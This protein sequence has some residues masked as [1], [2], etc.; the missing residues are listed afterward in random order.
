MINI[1][2]ADC[3]KGMA[4]MPDKAYQLAIV[5]PPYFEG[6]QK[7]KYYEGKNNLAAGG[8]Y[9]SINNWSVPTEEYYSELLRVSENQIIWG[10]NYYPFAVPGGRIVWTK[11]K[12]KGTFSQCEIASHSF[13]KRVDLFE[14][15]WNGFWQE[16]M[17]NKEKRIHPTQKP[18]ALYK[19][20]LSNYAKEGDKILDTHCGSGSILLAC[21]D[22]RFDIDAYELDEHYYSSSLQRLSQFQQQQ[23]FDL[24]VP[25]EQLST[26]K[27]ERKI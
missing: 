24:T 12:K 26:L 27:G 11:A 21:H 2:N 6:P 1:Y 16:D 8:K 23:T 15:L 18:V 14:F 3:M 13:Y 25:A 22:M 19:W 4:D 10:I 7:Q 17:K 20:L 9:E 5:D